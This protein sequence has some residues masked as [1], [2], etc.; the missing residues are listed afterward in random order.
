MNINISQI[1]GGETYSARADSCEIEGSVL[2]KP[3]LSLK[4]VVD[5]FKLTVESVTASDSWLQ[6]FPPSIIIP[7]IL[8]AKSPI[9][10]SQKSSFCRKLSEAFEN[11]KN[12]K[13]HFNCS[14]TTSDAN[15]LHQYGHDIITF[16]PGSIEAGVHGPN[17]HINIKNLI[18]CT[19]IYA[20]TAMNWCS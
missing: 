10:I 6:Q 16:G 11:I 1:K 8:D 9:N 19:K 20:L 12:E 4:E 13:P 3:D 17:E 15:Y 2:F 18:D 14:T 7:Y 5:Q